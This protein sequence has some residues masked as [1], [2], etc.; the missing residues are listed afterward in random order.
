[1]KIW[2]DMDGTIADLYGVENWLDMLHA[3]DPTPYLIAKPLLNLSILARLLNKAQENG[4]EIGIISW[5]ARGGSREY[6]EAVAEAKRKWLA[7]HLK[8]VRFDSIRII[9]YGIP[10]E[11]FMENF[12]DILFDDEEKNRK[13]WGWVAY[14]ETEILRVLKSLI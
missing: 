4:Y 2:F 3:S 11:N 13:N 8:S 6:N 9:E 7:T 5:T 10:K 12:C 1:M 14:E